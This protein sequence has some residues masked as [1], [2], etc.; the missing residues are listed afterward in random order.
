MASHM[1]VLRG[2]AE[3]V[4]QQWQA[5]CI[6]LN[7]AAQGDSLAEVKAKLQS[8]VDSYIALAMEQNDSAHQRDMLFRPAPLSL[9]LRYW[10]IRF[11]SLIGDAMH[12]HRERFAVLFLGR[13]GYC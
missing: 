3:L 1:L 6:D 10:Y 4:D 9:R 13:P 2:Y 12:D 11:A 7:L 8:M 5:F